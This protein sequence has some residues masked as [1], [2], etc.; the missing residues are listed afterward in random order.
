MC[1]H[2]AVC[3]LVVPFTNTLAFDFCPLI[4]V[5]LCSY[6]ICGSLVP[7]DLVSNNVIIVSVFVHML[8]NID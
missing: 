5:I 1:T 3:T 7:F 8:L 2:V 6:L 4:P